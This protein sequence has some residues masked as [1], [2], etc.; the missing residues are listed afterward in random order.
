MHQ[1]PATNCCSN[2][3][4]LILTISSETRIICFHSSSESLEM[5]DKANMEISNPSA[6]GEGD[7]WQGW[8]VNNSMWGSVW[9]FH[10]FHCAPSW[11]L[12]VQVY[13]D[14]AQGL[15][16]VNGDA[17]FR[18]WEH[19]WKIYSQASKKT[20]SI[21]KLGIVSVSDV[22]SNDMAFLT[23][24]EQKVIRASIAGVIA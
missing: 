17:D 16:R 9:P 8:Q 5:A 11:I 18:L 20:L 22:L 7:T 2:V 3:R 19:S 10:C 12:L 4:N 23:E 13:G 15:P 1:L 14:M 24:T 6:D 21:A